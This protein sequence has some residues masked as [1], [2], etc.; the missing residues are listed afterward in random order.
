MDYEEIAKKKTQKDFLDEK[1]KKDLALL[2]ETEAAA[3]PAA[4]SGL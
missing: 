3:K 2:K 4:V 1:I